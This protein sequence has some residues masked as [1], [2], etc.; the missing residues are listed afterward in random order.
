VNK[1][2]P[3]IKHNVNNSI[4]CVGLGK[5]G[6]MY[7]QIICNAGY[8]VFGLDKNIKIKKQILNNSKSIEPKLN[9]L[10]K[11]NKKNFT[12]TQNY[13]ISV[14]NTSACMLVL[15]TPSKKN[16]E[17]DNSYIFDALKQIGKHLKYKEKYIIN[18][19]STCNPGSC[20]Q[21]T[22]YLEKKFSLQRGKEFIFT[23]NPHLIALGSIYNDIINSELVIIGSDIPYGHDYLKKFYSK[24]Y[25]KNINKL[26]FVNL[27]EAEISKISINAFVT[28]KISFS[29]NLSQVADNQNNLDT[30]K[31][32]DIVGSDSRVGKK[33]LGLGAMFSGPC[34]PRD[35]LNFSQYLKKS[36]VVNELP[37]AVHKINQLQIN[38]YANLIK[39]YFKYFKGTPSIGICGIAYK[40]NTTLTELS[41]GVNL[42][43]K[44]NNKNKIYIYDN[45]EVLKS[46]YSK[47]KINYC[48]NINFF[49][50]MSDIIIVCYP[51]KKFLALNNY[52]KRKMKV[53]IDLWNFLKIK[54]NNIIYK[55]LGISKKN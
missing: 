22:K 3:K 6:L 50:D 28:M 53:V 43:K 26:K 2:F 48:N 19:T 45:R 5:L 34:F 27:K 9:Y 52:K 49:F 16:N 46:F 35:S 37:L 8:K 23:Y 21:F 25:K 29:N 51:N 33:Y 20:E 40:N 15:P 41:P 30:S 47:F 55:A 13:K 38:R 14:K 32:I 7:S 24:I 42:I 54:N 18:I 44:F 10:I 4:F 11:K 1:I 12:F 36:K 31:I 17:F 39:K